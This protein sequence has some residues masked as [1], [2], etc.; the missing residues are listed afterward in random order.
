M[1]RTGT[2]TG[3]GRG[4]R[5][6]ADAPPAAVSEGDVTL[7]RAQ[8]LDL[9][10]WMR[11][12][13]SLEERLVNLYRQTKVVGGLFRSLGQEADAV[14]SAYALE[15][16]DV[17]SPLIRNLGSM[18]VK[19]ATPVEILKQYMARGDSPTRGRELN[20]HFG[21]T[22]RGFI[23]Q[24]SPLGDMVP[25]MAGV[26]LSFRM[27]REPRVGLVYVGDGATSTGAFHE[28][29][30]FAAV[31]RCPLVVVV[32]NNGYAYSTPTRQQTLAA[33][34][35]DK[36]IGYGIAAEQADGNDVIATYAATKRAVDRARRGEG[37][38]LVELITYR[39]KGHAEHD[40]QSYVP[41]GEI[42]RWERENDPI[43]RYLARLRDEGV[44]TETLEAIDARVV[45]EID[46]ATDAAERSGV[47]EA[48]DALVGVYA[49]PPAERP[50]W[51]REGQGGVV[52][53]H[54][55]PEG[56]GTYDAPARGAD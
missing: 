33:Q 26:T 22:E 41:A 56:W 13:R 52:D 24:I 5:R 45:S 10:Y 43:T 28:G 32:E 35:V 38:T 51:F 11:L 30:N 50:L 46:E 27:R 7:T 12:T 40:N 25:V 42:D 54:E 17:L 21:D 23:G 48:L 55:R 16:G 1:A 37:V 9:Y 14:G 47:P 34:F 36:A 20:I 39:R 8:R 49:A 6:S 53:V 3:G 19:G 4:A 31:Q 15:P 29:I 2:R 44:N 18:L